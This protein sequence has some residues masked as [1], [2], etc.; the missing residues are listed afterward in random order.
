MHRALQEVE[1]ICSHPME[2]SSSAAPPSPQPA[3]FIHGEHLPPPPDVPPPDNLQDELIRLKV[4]E[5]SGDGNVQTQGGV[6][7]ALQGRKKGA[8]MTP[9]KLHNKKDQQK[10]PANALPRKRPRTLPIVRSPGVNHF[11]SQ[12]SPRIVG[13]KRSASTPSQLSGNFTCLCL[14]LIL[15]HV[16]YVFYLMHCSF[17]ILNT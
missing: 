15:S 3:G 8:S 1:N 6:G 11:L 17:Q 7:G 10:N 2:G 12:G 16:I 4:E 14:S 5:V 13:V 9:D